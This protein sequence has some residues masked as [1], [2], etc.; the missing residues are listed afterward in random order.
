MKNSIEDIAVPPNNR[1]E[2][3]VP[4]S[5]ALCKRKSTMRAFLS[6]GSCGRWASHTACF[7]QDDFITRCHGFRG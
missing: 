5:H 2:T 1:M 7:R 3:D 6:R 4:K